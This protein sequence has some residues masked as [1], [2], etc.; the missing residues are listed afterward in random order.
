M[1]FLRSQRLG[2]ASDAMAYLVGATLPH[3]RWPLAGGGAILE[4]APA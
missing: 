3:R 1:F 2:F 4:A